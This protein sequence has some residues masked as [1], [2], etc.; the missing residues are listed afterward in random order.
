MINLATSFVLIIV[1]TVIA[2]DT[3]APM[4]MPCRAAAD[5]DPLILNRP[6]PKSNGAKTIVTQCKVSDLVVVLKI[7][8][9]PRIC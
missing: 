6:V 1:T 8:F 3:M 7:D 5:A 9:L 4:T 2:N